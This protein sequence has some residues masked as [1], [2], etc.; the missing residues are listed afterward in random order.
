MAESQSEQPPP[1]PPSGTTIP[2][3]SSGAVLGTN[4]RSKRIGKR[5]EDLKTGDV[6]Y[7]EAPQDSISGALQLGITHSIGSHQ[8]DRDVL[9]QDFE[10]IETIQFPQCGTTVTP[11]H[12]FGDFR[13]KSYAPLAFRYFRDIFDISVED[14]LNSVGDKPLHAIG[15]PGASGSCF[16]LTHDDEFIIK[17]VSKTE[18]KFLQKLLP[19]YYLNLDQNPRTLLPKFYGFYCIQ[20]GGRNIRVIVMNNLMPSRIKMDLRFDLKGST[21]KRKASKKERRKDSNCTYKDLDLL[22]I[23]PTG[24]ELDYDMY[25]AIR[26]TIRR[27]VRVLSSFEIMDYSLLLGVHNVTQDDQKQQRKGSSETCDSSVTLRSKSSSQRSSREERRKKHVSLNPT[28]LQ[29]ILPET[30][31]PDRLNAMEGS[32]GGI[33]ARNKK[34]E[35]LCLYLGLIDILQCYK[36]RKKVEHA[37]KAFLYDGQTVSVTRPDRYADRFERFMFGKV[38]VSLPMTESLR[39]LNAQ[40]GKHQRPRLKMKE[41]KDL[42]IEHVE[43]AIGNEDID[44]EDNELYIEQSDAESDDSVQTVMEKTAPLNQTTP[45]PPSETEQS[46]THSVQ[47]VR[48]PK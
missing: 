13:F 32:F 5:K 48:T 39:Q 30:Q 4:R 2:T 14:Y 28:T 31:Q 36:T 34:G 9:I 23:L 10:I 44:D 37:W 12:N 22:D 24:I 27:D 43:L 25:E 19:G 6:Y 35:K 42:K 1:P 38:F 7:K 26:Q 18:A 33:P 11:S 46:E 16:W 29:N 21:F 40:Q 8:S 20:I 3:T 15:N 45:P 41:N 17:T 47:I